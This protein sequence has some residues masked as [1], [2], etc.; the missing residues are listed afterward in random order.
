MILELDDGFGSDLTLKP[1]VAA[2]HRYL[3][4]TILWILTMGSGVL[5]GEA[6]T[7]GDIVGY[8]VGEAVLKEKSAAFT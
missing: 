1:P 6:V 3:L 5:V 7:V 4:L 2:T 8:D